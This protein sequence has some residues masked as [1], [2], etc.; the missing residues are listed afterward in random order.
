VLGVGA[1]EVSWLQVT[2]SP[3]PAAVREH[4]AARSAGPTTKGATMDEAAAR[5]S[6]ILYLK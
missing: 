4:V 3:L 1:L 5:R 6:P 2:G